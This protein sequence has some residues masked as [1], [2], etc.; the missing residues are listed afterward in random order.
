[1]YYPQLDR[2]EN[3]I[4]VVPTDLEDDNVFMSRLR[5]AFSDY[6]I[7]FEHEPHQGY[8]FGTMIFCSAVKDD[9]VAAWST[10]LRTHGISIVLP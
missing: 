9:A 7:A 6:F 2:G 10:R 4:V 5:V 3:K 8:W 1:M